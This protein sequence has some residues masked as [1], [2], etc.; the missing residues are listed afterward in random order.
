MK[1]VYVLEIRI[2]ILFLPGLI[3]NG[4]D[5]HV[6]AQL[7]GFSASLE[8]GFRSGSIEL[9]FLRK[10]AIGDETYRIRNPADHREMFVRPCSAQTGNCTLNA[11]G[12]KAHAVRRALYQ[13][14]C[15]VLLRGVQG[16]V[17]AEQRLAFL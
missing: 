14:E 15:A 16:R 3:G 7:H 6:E 17:Y 13:I 5:G 8:H 10:I 4:L 12:M 9:S 11:D 1:G 2:R